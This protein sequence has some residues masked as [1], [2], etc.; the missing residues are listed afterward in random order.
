MRLKGRNQRRKMVTK[1]NIIARTPKLIKAPM[2]AFFLLR[3][4]FIWCLALRAFA[5]R[6]L[7]PMIYKPGKIRLL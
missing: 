3:D 5:L 6:S 2:E 7:R 4:F 1:K